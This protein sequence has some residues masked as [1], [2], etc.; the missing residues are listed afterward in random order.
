MNVEERSNNSYNALLLG[1][2]SIIENLSERKVGRITSASREARLYYNQDRN[3]LQHY[4]DAHPDDFQTL[5]QTYADAVQL[6]D[7]FVDE[8]PTF[9]RGSP[10]TRIKRSAQSRRT[11]YPDRTYR[12]TQR[13]RPRDEDRAESEVEHSG[14]E[15]Q[16]TPPRQ[17]RSPTPPQSSQPRQTSSPEPEEIRERSYSPSPQRSNAEAV[18]IFEFVTNIYDR[19]EAMA[20]YAKDSPKWMPEVFASG[21]LREMVQ[22]PNGTT[23]A[24]VLDYNIGAHF[25]VGFNMLFVMLALSFENEFILDSVKRGEM[26]GSRESDKKAQS[27]AYNFMTGLGIDESVR[28]MDPLTKRKRGR[29]KQYVERGT[30]LGNII[31]LLGSGILFY[32]NIWYVSMSSK[33]DLAN[34][35]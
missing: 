6:F 8:L 23:W 27:I 32:R 10:I 26:T 16:P 29:V 18:V 4:L 11:P 1:L 7:E 19:L 15:E 30:K 3:G 12:Q 9:H 25:Q 14:S 24:T 33:I 35:V 28:D 31:Q 34:N 5:Q 22:L 2:E 21:I 20:S 13:T 17:P